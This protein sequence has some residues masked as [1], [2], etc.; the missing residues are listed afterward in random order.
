MKPPPQNTLSLR[1]NFWKAKKEKCL[2]IFSLHS[3]ADYKK[4]ETLHSCLRGIWSVSLSP[5]VTFHRQLIEKGTKE[6]MLLLWDS[7]E[8]LCMIF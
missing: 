3:H 1:Q 6:G 2:F 7:D 4:L 8:E 5:S